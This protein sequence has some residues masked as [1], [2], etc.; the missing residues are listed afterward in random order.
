MNDRVSEIDVLVAGAGPTG[1]T[2]ALDLAR[3]GVSVR[4]IDQAE[5]AFEGSRAKG[6]QPRTQEVLD[7]LGALADARSQ[8]GSYPLSG[9]HLGPVVI[10][11]RMPSCA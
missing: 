10:P 5:R 8:G 2:L 4:L 6:V 9:I 7:D 1:S 3:R 11:W